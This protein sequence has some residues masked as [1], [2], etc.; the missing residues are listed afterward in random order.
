MSTTLTKEETAAENEQFLNWARTGAKDDFGQEKTASLINNEF[1]P[2]VLRE[3]GFSRQIVN[4]EQITTADLDRDPDNLEIPTKFVMVEEP[5]L[6]GYQAAF[7]DWMQ[8]TTDLWYK[9]GI[10][11]I[12]MLPMISRHFKM[13]EN[14]IRFSPLPIRQYVEGVIKNDFLEAEDARFMRLV[15][16][17]LSVTGNI[18]PSGN[19]SLQ[20]SDIVTL[21]Q[22]FIRL[23]L[24][25][26]TILIHEATYMEMLNWTAQVYGSHVMQDLVE[27][28]GMGQD[29]KYK[30]FAGMKWVTTMNSDIVKEGRMYG[31]GPSSMLGK[32]YDFGAPESFVKYEHPV[33]GVKM[34]QII[35]QE[36]LNPNCVVRLDF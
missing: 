5:I 36:I 28:G 9:G 10:R 18:I 7:T 34:R 20:L 24:P 35:A 21:R 13:T 1:V 14:Q 16:R 19:T 3:G 26:T 15:N 31:F 30:Q 22:A 29:G 8:S 23:R 12:R 6:N 11:K 2:F 32:F 33:L 17:C 4:Y 25:L 27:N